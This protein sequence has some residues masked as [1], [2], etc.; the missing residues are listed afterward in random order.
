MRY[1]TSGPNLRLMT[2]DA[3]TGKS[4][5]MAACREVWEAEGRKVIGCAVAGKAAKQLEEEAGI[6]SGTLKSLLFRLDNGMLSLP[7]PARS[8]S[9]MRRRW[10]GQR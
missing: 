2:G 8:S 10:S 6:Q 4:F 9:A 3:G 1:L 7:P 5:T